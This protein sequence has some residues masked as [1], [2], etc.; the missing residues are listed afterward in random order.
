[1]GPFLHELSGRVKI[2]SIASNRFSLPIKPFI[3]PPDFKWGAATSAYQIEGA[4]NEDGN[5]ASLWDAYGTR[6]AS[7]KATKPATRPWTTIIGTNSMFSFRLIYVNFETQ[8]RMLK[9]SAPW[10]QQVIRDNGLTAWF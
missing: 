3:F 2:L 6:C 9:S 5:R 4:G 7:P 10:Y 8:E 1:M